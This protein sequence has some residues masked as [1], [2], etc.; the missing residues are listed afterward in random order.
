[1]EFG[2]LEKMEDISFTDGS[3][4]GR[5]WYGRYS[6]NS[7]VSKQDGCWIIL[8]PD[9]P[10]SPTVDK[11]NLYHPWYRNGK[12]CAWLSLLVQKKILWF[13]RFPL[14]DHLLW[15]KPAAM[16]VRGTLSSPG[17]SMWWGAKLE[18]VMWVSCLKGQTP[19]PHQLKGERAEAGSFNFDIMRDTDP[20]SLS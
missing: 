15:G 3:G 10:G 9:V 18:R 5:G 4:S 20:E 13:L 8:S 16:Q 19:A 7:H 2:S 17:K 1:M 14:L 11:T 12:N 6:I